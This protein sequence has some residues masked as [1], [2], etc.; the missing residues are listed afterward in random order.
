MRNS[1]FKIL[2]F[3]GAKFNSWLP[4]RDTFPSEHAANAAIETLARAEK[5]S[6]GSRFVRKVVSV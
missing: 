3:V 1:T 2:T 6:G 4:S 5:A